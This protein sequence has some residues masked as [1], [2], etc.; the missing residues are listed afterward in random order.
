ML[1]EFAEKIPTIRIVEEKLL[2]L[3]SKGEI[4]GTTHTYIGM[5]TTAVGIISN[6]NNDQDYIVS[7]HR[8]HGHYIS[9][10]GKLKPFFCRD[11]KQ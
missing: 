1:N 9:F 8:N 10:G 2:D 6:L 3:F 7:N 5:E 4:Q 11:F